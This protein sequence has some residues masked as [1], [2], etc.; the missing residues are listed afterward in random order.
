MV[1]THEVVASAPDP[2]AMLLSFVEF[3]HAAAAD[4]SGWDRTHLE[5]ASPHGPDWWRTRPWQRLRHQPSALPETARQNLGPLPA[6][7][8]R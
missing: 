7:F 1:G 8:A 3:A 6:T 4:L 2:Q 5:Y